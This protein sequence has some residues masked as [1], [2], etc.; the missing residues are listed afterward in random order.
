MHFETIIIG[1]AAE[2]FLMECET[3]YC[4]ELKLIKLCCR[5]VSLEMEFIYY[6]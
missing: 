3:E 2:Q 4:N 6:N 1:A 5:I